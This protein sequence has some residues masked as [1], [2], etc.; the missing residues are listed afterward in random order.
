MISVNYPAL[1]AMMKVRDVSRR[2]LA[3]TIGVPVNT[4]AGSFRRH[5]R[6]KIDT[7][8]KIADRLSVSAVSL[9]DRSGYATEEAYQ[10]DVKAVEN[11]RSDHDIMVEDTQI[12]EILHVLR[13]LNAAGLR[14]AL[15][16]VELLNEVPKLQKSPAEVMADQERKEADYLQ[17]EREEERAQ[18][19]LEYDADLKALEA[20]GTTEEGI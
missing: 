3:I 16:L 8:W 4:L 11:G 7:L 10:A 5:T 20:G 14:K 18:L 17:M 9:V 13:N 2:Q 6:M 15:S 19:A 1:E 12:L